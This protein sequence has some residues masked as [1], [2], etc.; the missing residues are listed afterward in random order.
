[1]STAA[2]SAIVCKRVAPELRD[3]YLD[4]FDHRAFPDNPRW[5]SCYCHFPQHDPSR[6]AWK[7]HTAEENR[8]AMAHC[9]DQREASGFLAYADGKV[10]GWCNA[11][12]WAMYPMLRDEPEEAGA[13]TLGV[14]FCF[15]VEPAWR[16]KGVAT[17]LLAAA[18]DGLRAQGL[19]AVQAIPLESGNDAAANHLGP[20]SMYM[21]A[22]F[23]VLR[24]G[25]DGTVVV[26]K[27]LG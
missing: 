19:T 26:R 18:C 11:G 9:I 6:K 25:E 3:D 20:L 5:A 17:A 27:E 4:F 16:G 14:V 1:M 8:A 13:A 10:V 24:K 23:T 21:A 7:L 12:P 15:I 2:A 22:G